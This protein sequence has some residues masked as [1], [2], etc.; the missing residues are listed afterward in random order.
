[1]HLAR[2][3]NILAAMQRWNNSHEWASTSFSLRVYASARANFTR[4]S[5]SVNV[6]R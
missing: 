2:V 6:H 4:T 1:V 5:A 3:V